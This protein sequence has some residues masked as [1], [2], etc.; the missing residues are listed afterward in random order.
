MLLLAVCNVWSPSPFRDEHNKDNNLRAQFRYMVHQ[1]RP[2]DL[3]F[4][5]G[6]W[7]ASLLA[8]YYLNRERPG[9]PMIYWINAHRGQPVSLPNPAVL[10]PYHR[11]WLFRNRANN[12]RGLQ[13]VK[14]YLQAQY[15]ARTKEQDWFIYWNPAFSPS[16]TTGTP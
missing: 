8:A 5:N 7:G 3:V 4:T 12:E 9:Q 2:D 1:A 15:P 6:P 10:K 11:V 14:E 16:P 13:Q